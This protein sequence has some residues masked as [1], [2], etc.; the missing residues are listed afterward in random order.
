MINGYAATGADWDPMLLGKL[1][2]DFNLLCPDNRGM[3]RSD[4]GER[5]VTISLLADDQVS[6]LDALELE[7]VDVAGWSMGGFVAQELAATHP[8][9]VRNLTLLATDAGGPEA[10][11]G[12]QEAM[13]RLYDHSGTPREQAS[14]L[15]EL[16]FPPGVAEEADASFG[17]V[18]ATARAALSP[19]ALTAQEEAMRAWYEEPGERRLAAIDAPTL[20]MAGAKDVVIPAANAEVLATSIAGARLERFPDGGHA[21]IAQ[22]APAVAGLIR[23]FIGGH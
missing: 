10:I 9:R 18:V 8:E 7:R 4:L 11:L 14:R 22:E 20:V 21:F 3:G 6:L 16:L 12:E 23:E 2:R 13:A 5:E 19:L 17:E 1:A 15:I